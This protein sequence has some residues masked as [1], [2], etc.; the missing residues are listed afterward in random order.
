MR[1]QELNQGNNLKWKVYITSKLAENRDYFVEIPMDIM[2]DYTKIEA[3]EGSD[4]T[5]IRKNEL[6]FIITEVC[7]QYKYK[8]FIT[9][10]TMNNSNNYYLILTFIH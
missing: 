9:T 2:S 7:K 3:S 1:N 4:F 8:Y 10:R 5:N 6:L